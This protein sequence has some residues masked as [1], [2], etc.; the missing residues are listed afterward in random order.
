MHPRADPVP[1]VS[2]GHGC[3]ASE[4]TLL[5]HFDPLDSEN[6]NL[7]DLSGFS[8]EEALEK[9]LSLQKRHRRLRDECKRLKKVKIPT[10]SKCSLLTL[11]LGVE[12]NA[13]CRMSS[14]GRTREFS[15]PPPSRHV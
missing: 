10:S 8:R 6:S 15:E 9:Y 11:G 2:G 1:G 4:E 3:S 14:S 5:E 12:E 13:S 7:H